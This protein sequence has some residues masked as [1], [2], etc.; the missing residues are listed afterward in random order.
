MR[1]T[2]PFVRPTFAEARKAWKALLAERGFSTELLWVFE[3]NLC[4]EKDASGGL[5]LGYQTQFTPPPP[6]AEQI[7][8]DYFA[9]SEARI[10]FYR[11]GSSRG[12]SVCA[13]LCDGWFEG[14]G[15]KEGYVRRD[16]WLVSMNP[17]GK[18]ELEEVADEARFK[19]RVLRDRPIQ[20]LD[21]CMTLRSIHETLAHG[22]VLNS[23]EH[24]A[25]KLMNTWRRMLSQGD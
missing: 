11:L 15:E 4:F 8:Y 25:L 24:Y 10:V 23:Y 19:G 17:G 21:F 13:V 5:K 16:E 22:R 20:P 18:D 9:G 3:E 12:K 6:D 7:A 1:K 2:A 14:K